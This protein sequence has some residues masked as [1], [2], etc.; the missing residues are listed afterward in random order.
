MSNLLNHAIEAETGT[1][2]LGE[3]TRN[4]IFWMPNPLNKQVFEQGYALMN[5]YRVGTSAEEVA[6]SLGT[7]LQ[8]DFGYQITELIPTQKEASTPNTYSG[9]YG[10]NQ[11]PFHTDLAHWRTPPRYLM[12]RCIVGFHEVPTLLV[13]GLNLVHE[14][15][16]DILTRALVQPRRPINGKLPLLRLYQPND[17]N[18]LVRWDEVFF[19]PASKVGEL[20]V[21]QFHQAL[22]TSIPLS[23]A[24]TAP[25][26]TLIVDNWR[27]LHARAPVPI[28]CEARKL[29][30][31]YLESLN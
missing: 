30:R 16:K 10:C 26:D 31:V 24:L 13:D 3:P 4:G 2:I 15:G 14:V 20:G 7:L 19:Q 9:I 18:G 25:G 17:G 12:L 5:S 22:R 28:G 23:I 21:A 11:F 29:E 27:M 8:S 6:T 1:V